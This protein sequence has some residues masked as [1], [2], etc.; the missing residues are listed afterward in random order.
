MH[1]CARVQYLRIRSQLGLEGT[2]TAAGRRDAFLD[3]SAYLVQK[4]MKLYKKRLA[5]KNN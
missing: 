2:V 1:V 3:C 4:C 5:L